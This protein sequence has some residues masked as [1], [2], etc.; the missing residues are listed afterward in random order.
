MWGGGGRG[1]CAS[2]YNLPKENVCGEGEG[3]T[4]IEGLGRKEQTDNEGRG[5][6]GL[7][8]GALGMHR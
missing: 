2:V 3:W 6:E 1:V 4:Y 8:W 7:E 5:G